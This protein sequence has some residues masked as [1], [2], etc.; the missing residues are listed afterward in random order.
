MHLNVL[1]F[2]MPAVISTKKGTHKH[3]QTTNKTAIWLALNWLQLEFYWSAIYMYGGDLCASYFGFQLSPSCIEFSEETNVAERKSNSICKHQK[4]H[5]NILILSNSCA[6]IQNITKPFDLP[7]LLLL[8]LMLW[9]IFLLLFS[10][11]KSIIFISARYFDR[12]PVWYFQ[13]KNTV[14]LL[15][16]HKSLCISN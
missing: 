10:L 3:F 11:S 16:E 14:N 13:M 15:T 4:K 12:L 7:R 1:C 9:W 8:L 2:C 5:F 6:H